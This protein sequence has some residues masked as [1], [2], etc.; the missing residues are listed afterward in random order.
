MD[1]TAASAVA[2][3]VVVGVVVAVAVVVVVVVAVADARGAASVVS[4][5]FGSSQPTASIAPHNSIIIVF[6]VFASFVRDA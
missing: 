5:A 3:V 1:V 4:L 6:M 2:V